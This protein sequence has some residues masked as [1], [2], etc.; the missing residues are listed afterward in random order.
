MRILATIFW[1]SAKSR[2]NSLLFP[3]RHRR[4]RPGATEF[5]NFVRRRFHLQDGDGRKGKKYGKACDTLPY[6]CFRE[7]KID[8]RVQHMQ[9][10]RPVQSRHSPTLGSSPLT[11]NGMGWER[12]TRHS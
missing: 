11:H 12:V 4:R 7:K 6:D 2:E 10:G 1:G 8:A 3:N 5:L 9:R